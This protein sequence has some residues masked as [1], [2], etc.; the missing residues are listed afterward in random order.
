MFLNTSDAKIEIREP[1]TK[2]KYDPVN[3][4]ALGDNEHQCKNCDHWCE[5]KGIGDFICRHIRGYKEAP[6][7]IRR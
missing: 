5:E 2:P 6:A 3:W 7:H 1:E 4:D